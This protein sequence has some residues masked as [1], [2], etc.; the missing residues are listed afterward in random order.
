MLSGAAVALRVI[1]A[2]NSAFAHI[3][4]NDGAYFVWSVCIF[5]ISGF[6]MGIVL[7]VLYPNVLS[8]ENMHSWRQGLACWAALPLRR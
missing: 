5:V 2:P 4:D 8:P 3:R 7:S 1:T 6:L